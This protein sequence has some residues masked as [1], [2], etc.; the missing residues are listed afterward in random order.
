MSH[1]PD[2]IHLRFTRASSSSQ[3]RC[4]AC[5]FLTAGSHT[6]GAVPYKETQRDAAEAQNAVAPSFVIVIVVEGKSEAS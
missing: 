1:D 2:S 6:G 3:L 5:A 4:I